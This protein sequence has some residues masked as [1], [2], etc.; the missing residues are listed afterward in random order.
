VQ[1]RHLNETLEQ[2]V[3]E[4]VLRQAAIGSDHIFREFKPG[5]LAPINE[6]LGFYGSYQSRG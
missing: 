4:R 1:L 5:E 6:N 2:R 3:T